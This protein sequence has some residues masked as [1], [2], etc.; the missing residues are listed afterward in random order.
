[1]REFLRGHKILLL[2]WFTGLLL[3]M[4]V[5]NLHSYVTSAVDHQA[6][7]AA[8]DDD[9]SWNLSKTLQTRWWKDNGWVLYGPFY[10][11]L[12][13]SLQYF[14]G[15]TGDIHPVSDHETWEKTA[16]AAVMTTSLLSVVAISILIGSAFLELWWMRFLFALGMNSA[17]LSNATWSEFVLRAHPDHLFTLVAVSA[18]WFTV[19]M[20]TRPEKIWTKISAC[21]WGVSVSVKMTLSLC[22]PGFFLLFVPRWREGLRYLGFMLL[23]YFLIGFPQTIV[24]DRPFKEL[25]VING[26]STKPT[27]VSVLHWIS[28]YGEQLWQP[29]LIIALAWLSFGRVT[30]RVNLGWRLWTFVL[31]PFLLLLGKNMLVPADHYVMPF[32]S[33]LLLAIAFTVPCGRLLAKWPVSRAAIF[34]AIVLAVWG[35]TPATL[36][37]ELN[38]RLVCRDQAREMYHKV[39]EAYSAGEKI[40]VDPY[41]PYVTGAEKSRMELSWEK[42]WGGF[43]SGGWT[44]LALHKD[45]RKRFTDGDQANEYTRADVPNWKPVREFYLPFTKGDTVVAP[46]G[47]TFH[48]VYENNC[49]HEIW[50]SRAQP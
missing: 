48:R 38:K 2:T 5:L 42:T 30:A 46:N 50:T 24:L 27:G 44:I 45:F 15:L 32:A 12:N 4:Q 19:Y 13:H 41:V 20:F 39:F 6:I 17:L 7:V 9:A 29:L 47:T 8:G 40:W 35:S 36:Q 37:A 34:L 26:L 28:I 43:E 33:M 11:R 3:V 31:L 18:L 22:A 10:F 21:L 14:W 23:A 16:H 1:V 25:A 49:G